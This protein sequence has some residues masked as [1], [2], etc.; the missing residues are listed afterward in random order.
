MLLSQV[1]DVLDIFER[2]KIKFKH[3]V[4]ESCRIHVYNYEI[5]IFRCTLYHQSSLIYRNARNIDVLNKE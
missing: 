4:L 5:T 2:K 1:N 3:F